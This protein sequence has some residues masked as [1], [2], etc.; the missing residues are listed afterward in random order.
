MGGLGGAKLAAEFAGA[1]GLALRQRMNHRTTG[2]V[3]Q[4]VKGEIESRAEIHSQMTIYWSGWLYNM[5]IQRPA[6][7]YSPGS[8]AEAGI[9]AE[10]A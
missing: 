8:I 1:A 3:G 7:T 9:A 5:R 6:G 2:A 4:R 10:L